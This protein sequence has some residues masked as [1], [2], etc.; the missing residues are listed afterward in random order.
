M[1][2]SVYLVTAGSKKYVGVSSEVDQRMKRHLE[3]DY[4]VGR[5][6]RKHGWSV[7]ILFQ[8]SRDECYEKEAELIA[9]LGTRTPHGLNLNGGGVGSPDPCNEV[10]QAISSTLKKRYADPAALDQ[11]KTKLAASRRTPEARQRHAEAMKRAYAKGW[12]D[13]RRAA[14]VDGV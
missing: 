8:G 3:C 9:S 11:M 6:M 4:P 14:H 1:S 13:K 12:T 10:R 2:C 7:E 5:A